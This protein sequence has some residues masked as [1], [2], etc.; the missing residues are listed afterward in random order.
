MKQYITILLL[1]TFFACNP[2]KKTDTD[3]RFY[4]SWLLPVIDNTS[5]SIIDTM[6]M[7]FQKDGTILYE[8]DGPFTYANG[9]TKPKHEYTEK[10]YLSD[11]YLVTIEEDNKEVK[12]KFKFEG[13]D[14]LLIYFEGD[15]QTLSRIK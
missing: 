3:P 10:F 4:G 5:K 9:E 6:T 2:T 14:K 8:V 11:D 1:L 12:A 7:T 13:D 15:T